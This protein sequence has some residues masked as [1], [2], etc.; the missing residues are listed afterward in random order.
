M[1]SLVAFY[2]DPPL[3][4]HKATQYLLVLFNLALCSSLS[5][6][7]KH[8][9]QHQNNEPQNIISTLDN[10]YQTLNKQLDKHM[11][12]RV[13]DPFSNPFAAQQLPASGSKTKSS[14]NTAPSSPLL[15]KKNFANLPAMSFKG[16]IESKGAK[17]A[18]LEITGLGT[19]VVKK[20]DQVGLQQVVS[21]GAVL[22]ILEINDL[23]LVVETGSYGQ[24]MVVQ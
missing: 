8:P 17:L 14:S 11:Q 5:A 16:V 15:T 24:Q 6:E 10:Y 7:E 18:L 19:F 2:R 1:D 23:N 21:S 22:H 12:N 4:F 3:S 13:R 20:G 9:K